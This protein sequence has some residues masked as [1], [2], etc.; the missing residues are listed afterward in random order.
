MNALKAYARTQTETASR[1]RLMVM[2]F[3]ASLRHM[4]TGAASFEAGHNAEG[5]KSLG[6]ASDI[7]QELLDTLKM[8]AY[9][10]LTE[11]LASI[12]IFVIDRLTRAILSLTAKPA[13]EAARAFEPV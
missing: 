6:K 11:R 3:E 5:I 10:E 13:L 2:L 9:P 12:Y 1:E 4:R 7:V 8:D